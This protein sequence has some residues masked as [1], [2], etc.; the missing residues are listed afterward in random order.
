LSPVV[1][2]NRAQTLH[3]SVDVSVKPQ[4]EGNR[5]RWSIKLHETI[6]V[7]LDEGWDD[8][9]GTVRAETMTEAALEAAEQ[10]P[11]K[12]IIVHYMQ[13]HYPFVPVKTDFDK[14]YLHQMDSEGGEP[15]DENVWNRK[16]K[17]E[18]NASREEL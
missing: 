7:W 3:D 10:F 4:L 12:R 6:N 17:H 13:P 14:K 15:S 11:H 9:T 2:S 8:E 16:F 1:A 5:N 18:L